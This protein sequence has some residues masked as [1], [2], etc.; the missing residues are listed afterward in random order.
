MLSTDDFFF[1]LALWLIAGF[2]LIAYLSF[3]Y[4][5]SRSLENGRTGV[6]SWLMF[7]AFGLA[8]LLPTIS[9][10]SLYG[11]SSNYADAFIEKLGVETWHAYALAIWLCYLLMA[12]GSVAAG[13]SL[14]VKRTPSA[15]VYALIFLLLFLMPLSTLIPFSINEHYGLDGLRLSMTPLS[16]VAGALIKEFVPSSWTIAYYRNYGGSLDLWYGGIAILISILGWTIYLLT[17][18]RVRQTYGFDT[19]PVK[20]FAGWFSHV[21]KVNIPNYVE[22]SD[23]IRRLRIARYGVGHKLQARQ[24]R[25]CSSKEEEAYTAAYNEVNSS[26]RRPGLWAMALASSDGDEGV[27][28]ARYVKARANELLNEPTKA[29]QF[30]RD[31]SVAQA[32]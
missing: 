22:L 13:L 12:V 14:A 2:G 24:S 19:S 1:I 3:R 17:S 23:E 21:M 6:G 32:N 10:V 7:L 11:V 9:L 29:Q 4:P 28:Q 26:K 31:A 16:E 20:A 18:S 8:V 15:V 27:A 30:E 5:A 25:V